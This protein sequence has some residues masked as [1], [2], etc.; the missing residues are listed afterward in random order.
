MNEFAKLL[1]VLDGTA[2]S[3][4]V[5]ELSLSILRRFGG[6]LEFLHVQGDVTHS[7]PVMANGMSGMATTE[8]FEEFKK[9][10]EQRLLRARQVFD[11]CDPGE[12][13]SK[14]EAD[15]PL[16]HEGATISLRVVEG[17]PADEV[18]RRGRLADV[19]I[20]ARP[21]EEDAGTTYAEVDAALFESGR[22]VLL[23][24]PKLADATVGKR[25]G[26]AWDGS[27]EAARAATAAL[28]FLRRAERVTV[29][30]C[31][32]DGREARPSELVGFLAGHGVKAET[33][34]FK[35]EDGSVGKA[36]F[37]EAG[38]AGVNLMV[39]GGYGHSR[40]REMVLGGTTQYV[41]ETAEIPV[42]LSH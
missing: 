20:L 34:A 29:M 37:A 33:W 26:L 16:K 5:V 28:P 35:R 11:E 18:G 30:T 39:M 3:T 24:P 8:L 36:L 1:T 27:R 4:A 23:V 38:E 22:P 17:R 14:V 15:A 12:G 19:V 13:V 6:R 21:D 2:A 31:R 41:L 42:L 25:V 40:F 7:I 10:A 9:R 32:E